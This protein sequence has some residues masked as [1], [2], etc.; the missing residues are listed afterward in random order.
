MSLADVSARLRA[1]LDLD[2]TEVHLN[3][4]GVAPMLRVARGTG[5]RLCTALARHGSFAIEHWRQDY[6]HARASFARLVGAAPDDVAMVPTCA[7]AIS[8]VAMG[9]DLRADDEIVTWDQ[10]YPSNA[11]PWH[12]AARRAGAR[13]VTVASGPDFTVDTGQLIAA[14]GPRTRVVAVSWV[15]W[16][17][18][19]MTELNRVAEAC[20]RHGAWL[21]VD[22]IQGLGVIPFDLAALG[23]DAVCGGTHKWLCGPVGHGLLALAPGRAEQLTPVVQGTFTYGEP[24]DAV[25]LDRL[26]RPN[27]RRFE[28]GSPPLFGALAGAASVELLLEL[29]IA[30]LH[31][32]ALHLSDRIALAVQK[33]GGRVL[34]D[35]QRADRSPIVTF[36]PSGSVEAA[37]LSLRQHR[38]AVARRAG[39]A[40]RVSPHAFNNEADIERLLAALDAA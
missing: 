30:N 9:L 31:V 26:P 37:M 18:G 32:S 21:V 1:G 13:V 14:M 19:A 12:A 23:V 2:P 36:A 24:E 27:A 33:R 4:A 8:Y 17:T 7:A 22:A 16:Q 34:S 39:Q 3:N 40:I 35:T 29:G 11:Y 38:V 10:E 25:D 5:E 15:Q 6:A 20:R 28:P